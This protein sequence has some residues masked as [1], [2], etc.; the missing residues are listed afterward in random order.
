MNTLREKCLAQTELGV[1]ERE[2]ND[3]NVNEILRQYAEG[4]RN[5][6]LLSLSETNRVRASLSAEKPEREKL[7]AE[8]LD[9][10]T[11]LDPALLLIPIFFLAMSGVIIFHK[12]KSLHQS[13]KDN[14][15][16]QLP[17]HN[18]RYFSNNNYFKCAVHPSTVLTEEAM[19]CRD[20]H[21][22]D[23]KTFWFDGNK[24]N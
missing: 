6:N 14:S 11:T 1:Y 10:A 8:N 13:H 23:R 15:L 9:G 24:K 5:S 2:V 22:Q 19:N 20:Y 7:S 16:H 4:D 3:M 12:L 17:C 21:P 18:C